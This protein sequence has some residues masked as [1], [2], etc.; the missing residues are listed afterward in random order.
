MVTRSRY[1]RHGRVSEPDVSRHESF[2]NPCQQA[3]A[4]KA[5]ARNGLAT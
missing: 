5:G 3:R 4:T 1:P 2:L